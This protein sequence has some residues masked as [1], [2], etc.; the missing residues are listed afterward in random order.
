LVINVSNRRPKPFWKL[1]ILGGIWVVGFILAVVGYVMELPWHPW[2]A[3]RVSNQDA[4]IY[5]G[6]ILVLTLLMTLSRS[7]IIWYFASILVAYL[8]SIWKVMSV[9]APGMGNVVGGLIVLWCLVLLSKHTFQRN[10]QS[11]TTRE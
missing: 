4:A 7:M 5:F 1:C 11:E 9:K 6:V 8:G 2:I 3:D 10:N